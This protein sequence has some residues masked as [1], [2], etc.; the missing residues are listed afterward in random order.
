MPNNIIY[1]YGFFLPNGR[2]EP[3]VEGGHSK[4]A[5]RFCQRYPELVNLKESRYSNINADDFLLMGGAVAVAGSNGEH[6][7][8]LATGHP[9]VVVQEKLKTYKDAG[10]I[11]YDCWKLDPELYETLMN[12]LEAESKKCII[13][14]TIIIL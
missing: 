5:W 10:F 12:I 1:A 7:L 8:R 9:S 4:S 13:E 11:I 2:F 14:E 3:N 6:C